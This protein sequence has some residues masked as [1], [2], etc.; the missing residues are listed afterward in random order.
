MARF[1]TLDQQRK[2]QLLA[3]FMRVKDAQRNT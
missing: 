2:M 3:M 1:K